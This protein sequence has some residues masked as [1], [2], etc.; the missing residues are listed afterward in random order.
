MIKYKYQ[1]YNIKNILKR[2]IQLKTKMSIKI[3]YNDS[4]HN[5]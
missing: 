1:Y 3:I 2:N 5:I 4:I